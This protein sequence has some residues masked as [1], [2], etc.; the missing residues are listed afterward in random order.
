MSPKTGAMIWALAFLAVGALGFVDNP[1]VGTSGNAIFHAD[2]THNIVHL[3]SGLLFLLVALASPGSAR[4]VLILFGL[5]YL[6]LG[7]LGIVQVGTSG[8]GQLL[9]FLHVNG[10]DNYLHIALGVLIILTG[11]S[12]RRDARTTTT[13]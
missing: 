13:Y 5:V 7:V 10:N 3:A 11:L 4:S 6:A 1:I 9:G 2:T 8:M 12:I